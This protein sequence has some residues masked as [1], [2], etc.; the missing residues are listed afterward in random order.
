MHETKDKM[1]VL[2]YF[3]QFQ[4]ISKK[5]NNNLQ[6]E[7]KITGTK[8]DLMHQQAAVHQAQQHRALPP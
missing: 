2:I 5:K 4:R 3:P 8:K 7:G 6:E 1:E